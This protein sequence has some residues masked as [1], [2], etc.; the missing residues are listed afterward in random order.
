MKKLF[1]IAFP[2]TFLLL[3]VGVTISKHYSNGKLFSTALYGP[4]ESCCE[5]ECDCCAEETEFYRFSVEY[6]FQ[7]SQVNNV[8]LVSFKFFE[9]IKKDINLA[10]ELNNTP[11][12]L[13]FAHSPPPNERTRFLSALQ[14]F[15]L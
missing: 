2:L 5:G 1:H 12:K 4:A 11:F 8:I 14:V 15:L 10:V 6:T 7:E 13:L 9:G 3:T